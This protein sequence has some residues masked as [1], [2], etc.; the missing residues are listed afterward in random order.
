MAT[1]YCN[2]CKVEVDAKRRIRAGTFIMVLLTGL[3]WL[4][5]IPLYQK[6]CPLCKSRFLKKI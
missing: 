6:R 1:H 3:L 4:I 5:V 2:L